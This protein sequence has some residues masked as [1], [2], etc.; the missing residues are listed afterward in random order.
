MRLGDPKPGET[1]LVSSAVGPVGSVA[2]QIGHL[3]AMRVIGIAGGA[4][5]CREAVDRYGYD[6]CID[7][8]APDLAAQLAAAAPQGIDL[9]FENVGAKSLDPAPG[10]MAMRGRSVLCG[11]VQ[12][13]TDT[14]PVALPHFREPIGRASCRE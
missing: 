9:L 12:H 7:H 5:K 13:Y 3:R 10:L 2:G 11:L 1:L 6:V 8:N 4:E 14:A